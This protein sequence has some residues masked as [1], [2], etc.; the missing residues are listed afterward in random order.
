MLSVHQRDEIDRKRFLFPI[1]S[2][3]VLSLDLKNSKLSK[4]RDD[5]VDTPRER[6][7]INI[8]VR[9]VLYIND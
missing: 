8:S 2:K 9:D 4:E 7:Y 5:T 1:W 3:S 6:L